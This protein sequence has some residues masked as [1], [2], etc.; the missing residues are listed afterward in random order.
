MLSSLWHLYKASKDYIP[1][2]RR[3]NK[4]QIIHIAGDVMLAVCVSLG[5]GHHFAYVV[6][7]S[8][9]QAVQAAK[10]LVSALPFGLVKTNLPKVV[11]TMFILRVGGSK[12]KAKLWLWSI[13]ILLGVVTLLCVILLFAQCSPVSAVWWPVG[14]FKCWRPNVFIN[15]ATAQGG[16]S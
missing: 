7:K 5:T 15:A 4:V 10:L 12:R 6:E 11:I 1:V 16:R 2:K 8:E 9:K 13:N 14:N 3:A